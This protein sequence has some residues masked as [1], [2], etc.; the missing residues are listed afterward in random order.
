[1]NFT[2]CNGVK[3]YESFP[4]EYEKGI[5]ISISIGGMIKSSQLSTLKDV[6]ILL[7]KECKL[8]NEEVLVGFTYGQKSSG[9]LAS[10]FSRDDVY[11]Y[12]K[13]FI[14]TLK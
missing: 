2:E 4:L 11:W 14:G 6:K 12:G 3:F 8:Q 1:M 5:E 7:A 13:G 9:M 10:L